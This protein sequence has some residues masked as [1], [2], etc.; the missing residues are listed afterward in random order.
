MVSCW[1]SPSNIHSMKLDKSQ[2]QRRYICSVQTIPIIFFVDRNWG[3]SNTPKM[4]TQQTKWIQMKERYQFELDIRFIHWVIIT[5]H[6]IGVYF[7]SFL[8]TLVVCLYACVCVCMF[9]FF[10]CCDDFTVSNLHVKSPVFNAPI[11]CHLCSITKCFSNTHST[12][13]L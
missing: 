12:L 5:R 11:Y 9:T 1:L 3:K 10:C 13:E 8:I 4:C 7:K 2:Q 6:W